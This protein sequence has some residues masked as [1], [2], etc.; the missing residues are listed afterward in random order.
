[1]TVF[2]GWSLWATCALGCA[3]LALS[4][5]DVRTYRLPDLLTL[6]VL[7]GGL[8]VAAVAQPEA[9]PAHLLG[10]AAGYAALAG[11]GW[12]YRAARG[13]DGLG[14]GDAKLLAAGGAWLSW[15]ALPM[16]VLIAAALALLVTVLS[17][18]ARAGSLSAEMRVPFGP[19]LAAA[20]WLVWIYGAPAVLAD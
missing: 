12:L 4:I 20:I 10:A 9:L 16:V 18:L 17:Q 3:L 6:P 5:I 15:Q 11:I 14:R 1:M 13:R 7:A 19:Y 8:S 2:S